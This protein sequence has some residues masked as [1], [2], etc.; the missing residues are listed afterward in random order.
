LPQK[1]EKRFVLSGGY[2]LIRLRRALPST[3]HASGWYPGVLGSFR[4][5]QIADMIEHFVDPETSA[6]LIPSR[7]IR[8]ARIT[9]SRDEPSISSIA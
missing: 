2:F 6:S 5:L 3:H 1:P 9:Q 4:D 7:S 8:I